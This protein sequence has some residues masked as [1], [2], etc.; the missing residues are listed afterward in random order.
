MIAPIGL[1]GVAATDQ[2]FRQG[3]RWTCRLYKLETSD[4][5]GIYGFGVVTSTRRTKT[6]GLMFGVRRSNLRKAH[7]I[8]GIA[9]KVG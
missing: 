3:N 8:Y 1:H 7:F 4:V 9:L 2:N 5:N 6:F